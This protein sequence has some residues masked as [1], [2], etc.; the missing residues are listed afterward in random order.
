ML[1]RLY[2]CGLFFLF[3]VG[4]IACT[5]RPSGVMSQKKM[6][7]VQEDMQIAEALINNN[8][9]DY[10]DSTQR[11][12][13]FL[14]VFK[15]YKITEA[16]YD[17][18][19]VWYGANVDVYAKVLERVSNDLK[20]KIDQNDKL[21]SVKST[22]GDTVDI[23]KGRRLLTLK[24]KQPFN[25]IVFNI[26]SMMDNSSN[27]LFVLNIG[28]W[29][30]NR[31][32]M[33]KPQIRLCAVQTDTVLVAV[34]SIMHDGIKKVSLRALPDRGS[35]RRVYGII[36]MGKADSLKYNTIYLDSLNLYKIASH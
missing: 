31:D 32:L 17:S 10:M 25:G 27:S 22:S 21:E 28:V 20:K 14:G 33:Q 26:D 36:M 9:N 3:A 15:K 23:W 12:A 29:G 4:I 34:D 24:S 35:V 8:S 1:S 5:T 13:L 6:A 2:R 11:K 19:L 16:E 18:S 30:M 7:K